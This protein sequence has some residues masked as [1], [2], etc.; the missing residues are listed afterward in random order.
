MMSSEKSGGDEEVLICRSLPWRA[1]RMNK[2]FLKARKCVKVEKFLQ[3]R[4]R[5]KKRV[6]GETS[7]CHIPVGIQNGQ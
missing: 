7:S 1:E 4:P 3:A 6:L 5:M 2:F